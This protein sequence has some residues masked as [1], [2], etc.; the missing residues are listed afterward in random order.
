M[1]KVGDI[2]VC[3]DDD[4]NKFIFTLNKHGKYKI[5]ATDFETFDDIEYCNIKVT[6][7]GIKSGWYA[8]ERFITLKEQRKQKLKRFKNV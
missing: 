5:Y 2:V 7:N 4:N 3:I 6:V 8:S 1:F